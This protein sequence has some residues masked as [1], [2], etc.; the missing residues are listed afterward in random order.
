MEGCEL[1]LFDKRNKTR[2]DVH[3]VIRPHKMKRISRLYEELLTFQEE[4]CCMELPH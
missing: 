2:G 4:K 3:T 1:D